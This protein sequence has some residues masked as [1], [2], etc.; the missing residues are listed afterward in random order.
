MNIFEK[1]SR[2]RVRFDTPQGRLGTEELWELPL[3]SQTGR[4]NLDDIA[5]GLHRQLQSDEDIS[6]VTEAKKSDEVAI[7]KFD[8]VKHVIG[9]RLEENAAAA[10]AKE[11]AEK[12]QQ[13]LGL[14]AGK[15]NEA[16][17]AKPL[18]E[19]RKMVEAL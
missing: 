1:A 18:K 5:K 19:L 10:K 6:F 7:L 14:I 4:A 16:L 2:L 8:L 12:K 13:I 9:V 15:E 11:N 3:T 17:A